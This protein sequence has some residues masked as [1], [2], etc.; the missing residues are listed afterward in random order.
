MTLRLIPLVASLL[1]TE[2]PLPGATE[3]NTLAAAEKA[4]G[5]TS[6]F[7]GN[8]LAGWRSLKSEAPPPGWKVL[9]GELVR[10]AR[11]GDLVS[12]AEFGDF[13]LRLQWKLADGGNSGVLYR[14]GLDEARTIFTGPEFQILDPGSIPALAKKGLVIG[15]QHL[16]GAIADVM[17]PASNPAKPNGEWNDTR[18]LVRGWRVEH[19]LNGVKIV[20]LDLASAEGRQ[21]IAA[22][23][24]AKSTNFARL[25]RGHLAL[26]D[27]DERVSYR[28]IQIR[29]LK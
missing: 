3:P 15:P 27:H 29:T 26:Q 4:A 13:E 7:D 25:A 6:L 18:I 22:S 20:D 14:V 2:L 19:W 23:K 12:T 24:F 10:T 16:T 5:W 28:A 17:P 21:R 8:S 9:D 1:L 11:S